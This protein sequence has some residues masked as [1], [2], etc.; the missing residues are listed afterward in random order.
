MIAD[1][2]D[3]DD[4]ILIWLTKICCVSVNC[5]VDIEFQI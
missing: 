1:L 2:H 4:D 5:K 3:D